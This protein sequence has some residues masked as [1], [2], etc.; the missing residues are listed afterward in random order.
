[1]D[2]IYYGVT[3]QL[4]A[5]RNSIKELN[6][7]FHLKGAPKGSWTAF[8]R[9]GR[10]IVKPANDREK[11]VATEI[12]NSIINAVQLGRGLSQTEYKNY[13]YKNIMPTYCPYTIEAIFLFANKKKEI[14]KTTAPDL[15]KLLRSACDA[16]TRSGVLWVDDAQVNKI[17]ARKEN[18]TRDE[19]ILRI[20]RN[21]YHDFSYCRG[22]YCE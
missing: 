16:V 15:D 12:T 9:N 8:Q 17:T 4:D 5:T 10:T 13:D 7:R 22:L 21:D 14:E 19:I 2:T 11:K 18:S 6:I 20:V 3:M 1:M